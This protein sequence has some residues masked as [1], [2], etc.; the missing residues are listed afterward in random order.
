MPAVISASSRWLRRSFTVLPVRACIQRMNS[1]RSST[2]GRGTSIRDT[3]GRRRSPSWI[4]ASVGATRI[5]C[6]GDSWNS[7]S[8]NHSVS[9]VSFWR[10]VS[11]ICGSALSGI[12][13][14]ACLR[15]IVMPFCAGPLRRRRASFVTSSSRRRERSE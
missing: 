8:E 12:S 10:S 1:R 2:P 14:S 13:V 15:M 6:S 5:T 3:D 4:P 9:S 11:D 7:G